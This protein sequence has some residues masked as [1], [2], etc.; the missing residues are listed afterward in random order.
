MAP[1]PNT[2]SISTVE[3]SQYVGDAQKAKLCPGITDRLN[4]TSSAFHSIHN[5]NEH[6]CTLGDSLTIERVTGLVRED[7]LRNGSVVIATIERRDGTY[8]LRVVELLPRAP[9]LSHQT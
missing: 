2:A 8:R 7:A 1:N 6:M 4:Q 3:S 5:T 9:N